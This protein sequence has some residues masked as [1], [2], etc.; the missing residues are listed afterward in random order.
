MTFLSNPQGFSP[1][2]FQTY[3]SSLKWSGWRP[4][5]IVLHNTGAP[6]LRQWAHGN[7][8]KDYERHRI[9]NL[10]HYY[11]NEKGWHSGPHLFISPNLIWAA[12]DLTA[13]GVHASCYNRESI[14]VEMVGDYGAEPFDSGDGA[15]VRDLTAQALAT[16]HKALKISPDTLKFHK[17]CLRDHHDCPGRHVD[18]A[19]MIVRIKAAMAPALVAQHPAA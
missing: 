3:V 17:E 19:D 2:E 15:K 4:K 12:C 6:S 13:D 7:I 10:N 9:L 11:K 14:G 5:Y 1:A 8:G 18:K 16:L